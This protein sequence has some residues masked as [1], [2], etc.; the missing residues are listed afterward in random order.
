MFDD[1]LVSTEKINTIAL[2]QVPSFAIKR[3]MLLN[4]AT[5]CRCVWFVSN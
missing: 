4:D 1:Y 2:S 5:P 3:S